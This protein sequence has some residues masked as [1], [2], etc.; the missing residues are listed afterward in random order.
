MS[1]RRYSVL[2]VILLIIAMAI[3]AAAQD[4]EYKPLQ[5]M[6]L[7]MPTMPT[8]Q[9][10]LPSVPSYQMQVPPVPQYQPAPQRHWRDMADDINQRF[11]SPAEIGRQ[12][13]SMDQSDSR[14]IYGRCAKYNIHCANMLR[15]LGR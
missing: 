14:R 13:E 2:S 1:F 10:R 5:P 11:T 7:V 8:M 12:F 9:Y 6:R 15:S 3:P 4:F